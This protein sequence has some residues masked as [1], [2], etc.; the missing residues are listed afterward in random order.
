MATSPRVELGFSA[1]TTLAE[2]ARCLARSEVELGVDLS[3]ARQ[4]VAAALA[5]LD[6]CAEKCRRCWG[7]GFVRCALCGGGADTPALSSPARPSGRVCSRC[8][9]GANER[10]PACAGY[11]LHP[12]GWRGDDADA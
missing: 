5:A 12:P 11:G 7:A 2:A 8:A 1:R 4:H 9:G 3:A 10:C 6:D